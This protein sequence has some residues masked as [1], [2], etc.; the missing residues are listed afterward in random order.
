[1]ERKYDEYQTRR[2][3]AALAVTYGQCMCFR[4]GERF[5]DGELVKAC[6]YTAFPQPNKPQRKVR[7]VHVEDCRWPDA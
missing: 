1:M 7:L 6:F 5:K 3:D 4:C 2:W